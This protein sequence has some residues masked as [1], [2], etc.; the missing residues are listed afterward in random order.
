MGQSLNKPHMPVWVRCMLDKIYHI[1]FEGGP[2]ELCTP[3]GIC[4]YG[5]VK[6]AF[7]AHHAC[8]HLSS[9]TAEIFVFSF[10]SFARIYFLRIN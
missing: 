1:I 10:P 5:A 6:R 4:K 9:A 7:R 8:E 3:K 2:H